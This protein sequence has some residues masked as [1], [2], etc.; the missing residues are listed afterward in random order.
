MADS[1]EHAELT[2]QGVQA[3][4]D[5]TGEAPTPTEYGMI[6]AVA[7]DWLNEASK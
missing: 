2:A 4:E 7:R 6:Q 5:L 1:Q 3:H